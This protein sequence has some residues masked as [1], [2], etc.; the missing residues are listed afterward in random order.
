LLWIIFKSFAIDIPPI[1]NSPVVGELLWIPVHETG[2][3]MMKHEV[4]QGAW[5]NVMGTNPSYFYLCG[6]DCPV[7]NVSWEEAMEFARKLS[8]M[9]GRIYRLPNEWEWK[10]AAKGGQSFKYA[11]SNVL[12]EVGWYRDNAQGGTN[13]VCRKQK[14]GYGLCDMSGNV[15]EWMENTYSNSPTDSVYLTTSRSI[16]G[17]GWRSHSSWCTVSYQNYSQPGE[18]RAYRGFRLV[19][20]EN[21]SNV[22]PP[23][24]KPTPTPVPRGGA[25]VPR[26]QRM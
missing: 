17:G 3:Y 1:L 7:E 5:K 4:T 15:E 10:Y 24:E 22:L 20:S 11:G 9:E 2:F 23:P 16:R 13:P 12:E 18:R 6:S 26:I 14:N 19:Q 8:E 25:A 21:P